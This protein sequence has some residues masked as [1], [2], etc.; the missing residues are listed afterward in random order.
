MLVLV[1]AILGVSIFCFYKGYIAIGL[2]CLAGFSHKI[3]FVA[4]ILA[5]IM[6][7]I[8]GH[9]II[10]SIPVLLIAWNLFGLYLER[11]NGNL[12]EVP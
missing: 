8:K 9:W 4:L 3:G 7:L 11:K 2:I 10:G 6:L 5:S 12:P 1:G